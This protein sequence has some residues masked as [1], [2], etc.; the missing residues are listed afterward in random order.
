ML[1]VKCHCSMVR[2]RVADGRNAFQASKVVSR[3]SNILCKQSRTADKGWYCILGVNSHIKNEVLY[4]QTP[5]HG[6]IFLVGR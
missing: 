2:I 5:K 3:T 1:S 6:R 4:Y